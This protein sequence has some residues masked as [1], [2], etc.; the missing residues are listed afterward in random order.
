MP[1]EFKDKD[2]RAMVSEALKRLISENSLEEKGGS[3]LLYHF[4][5]IEAIKSMLQNNGK[6][7]GYFSMSRPNTV[8]TS[9]LGREKSGKGEFTHYMSLTRSPNANWGYVK[10][11]DKS[12]FGR[13]DDSI[14]VSPNKPISIGSARITFDGRK[15]SAGRVIKPIDFF[16]PYTYNGVKYKSNTQTTSGNWAQDDPTKK[17]M[18][19][20]A[21]DR[22]F[23]YT[24]DF[25]G[26]LNYVTRIDIYV[27][28][29]SGK[30]AASEVLELAKGT[31]V[32]GKIHVYDD[33]KAYNRP[34]FERIKGAATKKGMSPTD[35]RPEINDTLSDFNYDRKNK[36]DGLIQSAKLT[37]IAV[38]VWSVLFVEKYGGKFKRKRKINENF[39]TEFRFNGIFA[40]EDVKSVIEELVK[41]I[42]DNHYRETVSKMIYNKYKALSNYEI[43]IYCFSANPKF[44]SMNGIA[45]VLV[46]SIFDMVKRKFN[47]NTYKSLFTA[48]SNKMKEMWDG[49]EDVEAGKRY[50]DEKIM[51]GRTTKVEKDNDTVIKT[52]K[53]KKEPK[54][55]AR[56]RG[57][58]GRDVIV[59]KLSIKFPEIGVVTITDVIDTLDALEKFSKFVPP[60]ILK[61]KRPSIQVRISQLKKAL[62]EPS[63]FNHEEIQEM[64]NECLREMWDRNLLTEITTADAYT[65]FYNEKM[66]ADVFQ[67][68]MK[69]TDKMTPF[70]KM[71]LDAIEY[72]SEGRKWDDIHEEVLRMSTNIGDLWA[73]A[74]QDARQLTL[75]YLQ[76]Y[77]IHENYIMTLGKIER[78]ISSIMQKTGYTEANYCERGFHVLFKNCNILITCTTSY[79]ASKKHYGDSH[80]CTA[81]DIFGNY[82]GYEMFGK[83]TVGE[84]NYDYTGILVQFVN[85]NDREDSI[86]VAFSEGLCIEQAC[87]FM[88][89]EIDEY[90][91]QEFLSEKGVSMDDLE[92]IIP[93][94]DLLEETEKLFYEEFEYWEEKKNAGFRKLISDLNKT[95][96]SGGFDALLL[97]DLK[98]AVENGYSYWYSDGL[99]FTV[100]G[101][102]NDK[103]RMAPQ[104][105]YYG[106]H[107]S[108]ISEYEGDTD[109]KIHPSDIVLVRN[110][111]GNFKIVKRIPDADF[112]GGG[113]RGK[114]YV[115]KTWPNGGEMFN[116]YSVESLDFLA[117]G[118]SMWW[119][120]NNIYVGDESVIDCLSIP[121]KSGA[122][123]NF[124][125]NNENSLAI[126]SDLTGE[127]RFNGKISSFDSKNGKIKCKDGQV[128]D[129]Y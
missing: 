23:G 97:D 32:E 91:V 98:Y 94:D 60:E 85:P 67:A 62:S 21:E 4:T 64:V 83:Y 53:P 41:P 69:G 54:P 16:G 76:H 116:L 87:D 50:R 19:K 126:I 95:Y 115:I 26:I 8:D 79:S 71:C 90:D 66:P 2:I 59:P 1:M 35:W 37:N 105:E 3:E 103:T 89:K 38:F 46:N 17:S 110:D 47:F 61:Q 20:Q 7:G 39:K 30:N 18:I 86:Q 109:D 82:N 72:Y 119:Y 52:P 25:D 102:T 24:Y 5:N 31:P 129:A 128:I 22:L 78:I 49:D 75:R 107:V 123:Y 118:R 122:V 68:I 93:F 81:S 51:R 117:S 63:L 84:N 14:N 40:D 44:E 100:Y 74:N 29:D 120:N 80:W 88:D 108:T 96:K 92:A 77:S 127:I 55:K 9:I 48:A 6:N 113:K 13:G 111:S 114:I 101:L 121:N 70:H 45:K 36:K 28:N 56:H 125:G 43:A 12:A 27:S 34:D 10:A 57:R 15:L 42:R 58:K 73:N 124:K 33:F 112:Y 65:R 99:E 11:L 104:V 106:K